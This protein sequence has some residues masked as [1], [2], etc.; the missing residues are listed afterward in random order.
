MTADRIT[1]MRTVLALIE[2]LIRSKTELVLRVKEARLILSNMEKSAQSAEGL[3]EAV[4]AYLSRCDFHEDRVL[5]KPMPSDI[6][7][8]SMRLAT[9]AY[10]EERK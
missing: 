8:H 5:S 1:K 9:E 10:E 7:V 4:K 2:S 6:E 3:A